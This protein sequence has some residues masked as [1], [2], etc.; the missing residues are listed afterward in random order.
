MRKIFIGVLAVGFCFG[1]MGVAG[2]VRASHGKVEI[3]TKIIETG[4]GPETV[5]HSKVTVH[6]T[7]WLEDGTKFDASL[8]RGEPFN[9]TLGTGSVIPG[10]DIGIKGMKPGEKREL[11]ILRLSLTGQKVQVELSRRMQH[12]DLRWNCSRRCLRNIRISIVKNLRRCCLA[13]LKSWISGDRMNGAKP[14]S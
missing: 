8:D 6:Y 10:W 13:A 11:I 14:V 5:R 12:F 4:D 9:F 7:G 1:A 3:G 2:E